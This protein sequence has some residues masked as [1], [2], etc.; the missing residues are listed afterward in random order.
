MT[1]T[2]ISEI[3]EHDQLILM[4]ARYFQQLGY[5]DIKADIPGW[6]K[7]DF[8]YWTNDP[9][10][11]FYPDLTCFDTA[12]VFIILEAETCS[13]ISD[14]HTHDQFNIFR[15]H[16]TNKNGRFEVVIPRTCVGGDSRELLN[17]AINSWSIKLDNIWTP[18]S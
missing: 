17:K 15:A 6:I 11:K 4:M 9:N 12:G 14:Q 10:N 18:N 1:R 3:S 7:P 8:V 13:T 2:A 5:T 16:A